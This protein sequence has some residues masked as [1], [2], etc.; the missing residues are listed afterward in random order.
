MLVLHFMEEFDGVSLMPPI[1]WNAPDTVISSDA[2]LKSAGG[3]AQGEAFH[4]DFPN[5]IRNREGISINKLELITCVVTLK[6]WSHQIQ[7]R[8]VLAY[9]D[10]ESSVEV[11]NSGKH[12][13]VSRKLV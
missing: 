1:N 3:W 9:C 7:N 4:V 8:N 5:W 11:V 12:A 2:C 13:T 10:N 6:V